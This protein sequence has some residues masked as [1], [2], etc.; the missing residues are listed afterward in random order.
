MVKYNDSDT[1]GVLVIE[2]GGE[3]S[4]RLG[5]SYEVSSSGPDGA[6]KE[7]LKKID[8]D[9]VVI[10]VEDRED[11]GFAI[12]HQVKAD[13]SDIP[14]ILVTPGPSESLQIEGLR[15]GADDVIHC[16]ASEELLKLKID[17]VLLTGNR[18]ANHSEFLEK[19]DK[20]ILKNIS[21]P[22]FH[23]KDLAECLKIDRKTLYRNLMKEANMNAQSYVKKFRLNFADRLFE[24]GEH[25]ISEISE[26]CGFAD[27]SYFSKCF[28]K[29]FGELPSK[30]HRTI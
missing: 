19:V 18:K 15:I 14:V 26:L 13:C 4:S 30:R 8:P 1:P 12:C 25:T 7:N 16:V 23:V 3:I 28:K 20:C 9:V 24:S 5:S 6:K 17:R 27:V 2:R 11:T 22:G 21:D 29:E 10:E